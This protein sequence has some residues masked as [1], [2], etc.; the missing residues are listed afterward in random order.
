MNFDYLKDIEGL[1]PL[2]QNCLAAETNLNTNPNLAAVSCRMGLEFIVKLIYRARV[3]DNPE[4]TDLFSLSTDPNFTCLFQPATLSRLNEVRRIGNDAAH[5][6]NVD[7]NKALYALKA[8]YYTLSDMLVFA[9]FLSSPRPPFVL[10]EPEAVVEAKP[11]AAPTPEEPKPEVIQKAAVRLKDVNFCFEANIDEKENRELAFHGQ[12]ISSGWNENPTLNLLMPNQA[13]PGYKCADGTIADMVLT[14]AANFP[15]AVIDFSTSLENPMAGRK[16]VQKQMELLEAQYHRKVAGYYSDG[17]VTMFLDPCGSPARRV[18]EYHTAAELDRM[19]LRATNRKDLH[20]PVVDKTITNRKPIVEAVTTICNVFADNKRRKA[21][22]VIATGVGKTRLSIALTDILLKKGWATRILFLA[23]RTNLVKQACRA[24]KQCL[25]QLT[26]S[27]YIGDNPDKDDTANVV[28]STYQTMYSLI[29]SDNRAF[30]IGHFDLV[31]V[32]EAHRSIFNRYAMLFHYFDAFM[33][34]LTA[35]PREENARSTYEVFDIPSC[36]PDYEYDLDEAVADGYLVAYQAFNRATAHSTRGVPYYKLSQESR[37]RIEAE[38]GEDTNDLTDGSDFEPGVLG[39]KVINVGTI[40]LMLCD[41]MESGIKIH[42]GDDIGKTIIFA[43]SVREAQAIVMEFRRLFPNYGVDYIAR[44]DSTLPEAQ[45]ILDHFSVRANHPQIVVSVDMLDTGVDVPDILNLVFFK[46]VRSK[47]KFVQMIGRG[48]R[49]S[50]DIFGKDADKSVFY[51]FDYY[52]NFEYFFE[53]VEIPQGR[54]DLSKKQAAND[55]SQS[56]AI[57]YKQAEI[58][59]GIHKRGT[60]ATFEI[61]YEKKLRERFLALTLGL[62]NEVSAVSRNLSY[63]NHYRKA[64]SWATLDKKE[65]PILR[66]HIIPLLPPLP[67]SVKVKAFDS[68]IYSAEA[69][70]AL[71]GSMPSPLE[72]YSIKESFSDA[73]NMRAKWLLRSVN[74]PQVKAKE[75]EV[76]SLQNGDCI[77]KSFSMENCENVRENLRDLMDFLPDD[78][79]YVLIDDEDSFVDEDHVVP[80]MQ[81]PYEQRAD[82]YLQKNRDS[83]AALMKLRSL[84]PLT[85]DEKDHLTAVFEGELG[86]KEDL[87]Q[88][89]NGASFLAFLR[90]KLGIDDSAISDKFGSFYGDLS[91]FT[92]QQ[93]VYLDA[94]VS[95]AKA[96]GDITFL[97]L[98]H[99]PF[100]DI[101]PQVR[102]LFPSAQLLQYIKVLI[103]GIHGAIK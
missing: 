66:Q 40:D 76:A 28:L 18:F 47:I 89:L 7:Y 33:I 50:K 42:D 69:R 22:A 15:V 9:G 57:Y 102:A 12:L 63:V 54:T 84:D 13:N 80:S 90:M 32:D 64:S 100:T 6:S 86:T 41:L 73:F 48:T 87:V 1:G 68:L 92:P 85:Q 88:W 53:H 43:S 58:L 98:Q 29:A 46:E 94:I 77:F 36:I 67:G 31:I 5:K 103:D 39:R 21:L 4:K 49:T 19:I 20:N 93:M 65:L 81:K 34:G 23:D 55:L 78:H 27:E 61:E 97:D 60:V 91:I 11:V 37:D 70:Y 38:F 26:T 51:I 99:S 10:C 8:L 2:A 44:I 101:A 52:E 17:Y 24:F 25:P 16:K 96:N 95:F 62:N 3:N 56:G 79:R 59:A 74:I 45:N 30:G 83:D 75:K 72:R 71:R 14:D 35:T 82:E